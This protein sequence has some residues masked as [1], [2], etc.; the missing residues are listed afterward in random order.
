MSKT[1]VNSL[2]LFLTLNFNWQE[3]NIGKGKIRFGI[4]RGTLILTL[5]NCTSPYES[6]NFLKELEQE[7]LV[8]TETKNSNNEKKSFS[9]SLSLSPNPKEIKF[10]TGL[11]VDG[12]HNREENHKFKTTALQV[13]GK[14]SE[15]NPKWDFEV[16]D[17]NLCLK[18]SI[19]KKILAILEI[20]QT[21]CIIEAIFV[22]SLN[23]LEIE[24][25]EGTLFKK[26]SPNQ[27]GII[28]K[29]LVWRFLENQIRDYL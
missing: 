24:G 5:T 4:N 27:R 26:I 8:E 21:P 10:Q 25:I 29:F 2:E 18:R 11:G 20:T 22:T 19:V 3:E 6:R 13:S 7:V 28:R 1:E 23:N 17:G 16:K 9:G 12:Q 15:N 14:G